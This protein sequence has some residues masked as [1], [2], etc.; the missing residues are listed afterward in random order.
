MSPVT[1][2]SLL[3]QMRSKQG[4]GLVLAEKNSMGDTSRKESGAAE[5]LLLLGIGTKAQD[6][7][8][9]MMLH[10]PSQQ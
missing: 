7:L 8:S 1:A 4:F 2:L 10:F 3:A 6:P 9:Q 5:R